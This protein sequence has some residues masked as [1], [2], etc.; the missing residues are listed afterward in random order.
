MSPQVG[1]GGI[2]LR[3]WERG[4]G[5]TLAC[6]TGACATAVAAIAS[7][8]ATSPVKVTMPGG[9][10]T[11]AWAPGEPIR[12]RGAATYVFKGEIDL[13]AFGVSVETITL[14]CR[15]NFAESEAMRGLAPAGEDWVIVNSCAV[16]AEAVRQTRQAIRRARRERPDGQDPRHRLRGPARARRAFAAMPE[17]DRIQIARLHRAADGRRRLSVAGAQLRRGPDR[18]RPSLHLLHHLEARGPSRSLP[19]EAIRDGGR[20]GARQRRE[21]DRAHRRRHH[22]LRRRARLAVPAA[23]GRSAAASS[24]CACRRSTA[25]RST[26]HCSN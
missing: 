17:V 13:E 11:I 24:A 14:G 3:T 5:L 8:R 26:T 25:S 22:Q 23:A 19:F 16:T 10:L 7:K 21:G 6:G 1:S 18:L 15:L 4:A 9:T 12:M 2:R 20:G